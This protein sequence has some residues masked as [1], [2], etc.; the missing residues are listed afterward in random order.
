[1]G[2][3]S[4]LLNIDAFHAGDPCLFRVLVRA[5]SPRLMSLACRLA[6][7]QADAEDL[8]QDTWISAYKARASF[9]GGSILAWL[10]V[11]LR[12]S[13]LQ[14]CRAESRRAARELQFTAS[15]DVGTSDEAASETESH[16]HVLLAA[17]DHLAPRQR[18]VVV[19]RCINQQ[20]TADTARLLGMAEGTVKAT[21][22][23]ALRRLRTTITTSNHDLS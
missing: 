6:A 8:L 22:S 1:M 16:L 17:L 2:D 13:H 15:M 18:A 11:I 21:L 23:Q 10:M 7:N 12:R 5:H 20:S 3:E 9:D 4:P 14:R 19:E